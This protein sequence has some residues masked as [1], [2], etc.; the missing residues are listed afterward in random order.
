[1]AR[2]TFHIPTLN[3][4]NGF[5]RR[6]WNKGGGEA[7]AEKA[8][9]AAFEK[10]TAGAYAL[11][12]APNWPDAKIRSFLDSIYGVWF[13]DHLTGDVAQMSTE[14]TQPAFLRKRMAEFSENYIEEIGYE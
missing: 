7:Y 5:F 11:D 12:D 3:P 10:V 9:D 2:M 13:A 14:L 6:A 1:M 8:W 4:G